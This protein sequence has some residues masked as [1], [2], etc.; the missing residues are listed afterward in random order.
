[1]DLAMMTILAFSGFLLAMLA[2]CELGRRFG[3]ARIA[4]DPDGLAKGMGAADGAVFALL[5]LLLA[6]TFSG[7]ASRFEDRRH[8]VTAEANAIGTAYLRV[9]LLSPAVQPAMK[10]L[11]RR[12]LDGRFAAYAKIQA[13]NWYAFSPVIFSYISKRLP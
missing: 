9:D 8:L 7:A 12:Y 5:G 3:M 13:N 1:M 6:F 2:V 11:F 4:R 10:D